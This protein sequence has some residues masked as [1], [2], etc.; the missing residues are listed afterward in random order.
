MYEKNGYVLRLAEAK[1]ASEYYK[2]NYMPLEEETARLTGCKK[3]F[4]EKEVID[5][6]MYC[7][8]DKSRRF[9]LIISPDGRIIGECVINEI[10]WDLRSANF[11]IGIFHSADCSRGIGSWATEIIR[12]FAFEELK[13]HRLALDVF[14]FN[15]RAIK[16]YLKNGFHIEGV[17]RDAVADGKGYADIILMSVLENDWKSLKE[18]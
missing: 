11:R 10:D 4:S 15:H 14:S 16:T 18:L 1:D 7:L 5:F 2:Q 17:M 12:D 9:F 8:D 13:L 3:V 6:F